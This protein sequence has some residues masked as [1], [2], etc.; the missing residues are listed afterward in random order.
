MTVQKEKDAALHHAY[1]LVHT[2]CARFTERSLARSPSKHPVA[3]GCLY[4]CLH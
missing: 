1:V 4:I 3:T 2:H